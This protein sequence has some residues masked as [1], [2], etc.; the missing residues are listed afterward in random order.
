MEDLADLSDGESEGVSEEGE[1]AEYPAV[2][3]RVPNEW[4]LKMST[5]SLET[6]APLPLPD[7]LQFVTRT[8]EAR[9]LASADQLGSSFPSFV[10]D[11]LAR[12]HASGHKA[13]ETALSALISGVEAHW[14]AHAAVQLFGEL[15]GMLTA[16]HS[17]VITRRALALLGAEAVPA[18]LPGA[19]APGAIAH[20]LADGEV[21]IDAA[22]GALPRL[23]LSSEA[24][25]ELETEVRELAS[26]GE[27]VRLD[28]LLVSATLATR[29]HAER[30]AADIIEEEESLKQALE[31]AAAKAAAEAA[32]AGKA[33]EDDAAEGYEDDFDEAEEGKGDDEE[34][35]EDEAEEDEEDDDEEVAK[36]AKSPSP[37]PKAPP[38]ASKGDTS[39][40]RVAA[41]LAVATDVIGIGRRQRL[42]ED[43]DSNT[44]GQLSLEEIEAS[45]PAAIGAQAAEHARLSPPP[46]AMPLLVGAIARAF[47][48][49]KE[50]GQTAQLSGST[51]SRDG[52]DRVVAYLHATCVL[53]GMLDTP[54]SAEEM[55]EV[56]EAAFDALL[57]KLPP[58]WAPIRVSFAG[59]LA[60]EEDVVDGEAVVHAIAIEATGKLTAAQMEPAAPFA[61]SPEEAYDEPVDEEGGEEMELP[62]PPPGGLEPVFETTERSAFSATMPLAEGASEGSGPGM[63]LGGDT[64]LATVKKGFFDA[65]LL[66]EGSEASGSSPEALRAKYERISGEYE[67]SKAECAGARSEARPSAFA[68]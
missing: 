16:E 43:L 28:K 5:R 36:A 13:A 58:S 17:E 49:S 44:D 32:A 31:A 67:R 40:A 30:G 47:T 24:T 66:T 62:P 35:V 63:S 55:D 10:W 2:E 22:I 34:E 23:R 3:V 53:L 27:A 50:L 39:W 57:P 46:E 1:L 29:K 19:G 68:L 15:S 20:G 11:S 65:S 8:I 14:G 25:V 12:E 60:E 6:A 42:F 26:G 54:A 52:F 64:N 41:M 38:A 4:Q 51:I 61:P 48:A 59:L 7:L 21:G 56:D 37:P 33:P 9:A 18:L 45:L